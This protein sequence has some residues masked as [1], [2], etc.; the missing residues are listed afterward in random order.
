M[1]PT[2]SGS[3]AAPAAPGESPRTSWKYSDITSSVP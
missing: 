3:S 2:V 1:L